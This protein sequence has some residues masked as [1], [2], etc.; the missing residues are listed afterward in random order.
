MLGD[1]Y[2]FRPI[3]SFIPEHEFDLIIKEALVFD[4]EKVQ[5]LKEWYRKDSNALPP[6]YV[7]QVITVSCR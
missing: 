7:L 5:T 6:V 4:R 2:G 1:R 3:P